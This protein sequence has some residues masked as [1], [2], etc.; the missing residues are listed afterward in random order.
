[1]VA[2][3]SGVNKEAAK[4]RKPAEVGPNDSRR[5]PPLK[6]TAQERT[7]VGRTWRLDL[8]LELRPT[9]PVITG[10]VTNLTARL[11]PFNANNELVFNVWLSNAEEAKPFRFAIEGTS[12]EGGKTEPIK[13]VEK[14]H[15]VLDGNAIELFRVEQVFDVRTSP[16]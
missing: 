9:G 4:L 16:L 2:A 3:L 14:K 8:K 13:F 1:M 5:N 6:D 10:A 7:F 11:Q 15:T 12:L